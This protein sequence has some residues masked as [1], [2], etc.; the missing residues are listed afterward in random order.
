MAPVAIEK[1][2]INTQVIQPLIQF[3][4]DSASLVKKCTKPDLKEFIQ[5]TK[6]TTLGFVLM[7]TIGF[8]VKLIHIPINNI[9][10]GQ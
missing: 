10:V 2:D 8:A 1:S 3:A 7:G 9:L 6:A 5:I 4:R